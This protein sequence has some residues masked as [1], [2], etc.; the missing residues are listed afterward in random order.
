MLLGALPELAVLLQHS[1]QHQ[2]LADAICYGMV[3]L[4]LNYSCDSHRKLSVHAGF[5]IHHYCIDSCRDL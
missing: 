2:A 3:C 1:W 4:L 5:S